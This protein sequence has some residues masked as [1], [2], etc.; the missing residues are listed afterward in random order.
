MV[1]ERPIILVCDDDELLRWVVAD[2]LKGAGYEVLEAAD[3]VQGM[4]LVKARA[5]ACVLMDLVMPVMD[6]LTAL[7]TLREE[8]HELPIIIMTATGGSDSAR[9]ARELGAQGYL[10]KPF[11]L[12]EM[13]RAVQQALESEPQEGP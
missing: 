3:G 5:P 9:R 11:E 7:E 4:A 2:Y 1:I 10:H 13:G 8:G 12:G 6:G